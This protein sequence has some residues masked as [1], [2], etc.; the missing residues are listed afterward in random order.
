MRQDLFRL[1]MLPYARSFLCPKLRRWPPE[2]LE[3]YQPEEEPVFT[4]QPR[5]ASAQK[6]P[7]HFRHLLECCSAARVPQERREL[8]VGQSGWACA[9]K[10]VCTYVEG[11]T[12]RS[13]S[14][15]A[16]IVWLGFVEVEHPSFTSEVDNDSL[17]E[18]HDL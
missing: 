9:R 8:H 13:V 2:E 15:A 18:A 5:H 12:G 17:G 11:V 7:F 16:H 6:R 1:F 10:G 4:P 14:V 3:K